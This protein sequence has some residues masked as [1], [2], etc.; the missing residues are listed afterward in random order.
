MAVNLST[1]STGVFARLGKLFGVLDRTI[2]FQD[3]IIDASTKSFQEAINEYI[4]VVG[5]AGGSTVNTDLRFV[6]NLTQGLDGFRNQVYALIFGKLHPVAQRTLVEMMCD[7]AKIANKSV[8]SALMELRDQM[9][10]SNDID[11]NAIGTT[12]QASITKSRANTGTVIIGLLPGQIY[13][14]NTEKIPT[15][16]AETITFKCTSDASARNV[17]KGGE[18]FMLEGETAYPA[19]DH[20]WPGGTGRMAGGVCTSDLGSDGRS[21]GRN[22]L[23]NSG[24]NNFASNVPASWEIVTGSAG[25]TIYEE[26]S[27]VARGSSC[28]KMASD[29]STTI[30]IKQKMDGR[31]A[32]DSN[33][34]KIEAD[35][36]CA[37][38]FLARKSGS[39]SAGAL[40]VGLTNADGFSFSNH[41]E[42]AHGDISDSAWTQVTTSF[43]VSPSWDFSDFY[44][45]LQQ[46]TA[47][48][49]GVNLFIDGLVFT[50]M[51]QTAPGGFHYAVVPGSVDFQMG[52]T[53]TTA[54]T[55]DGASTVATM[56]D[57]FFDIYHLG[58]FLPDKSDGSETIANSIIA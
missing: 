26:T 41:V 25:G 22:R 55:N 28:L 18:H 54:N 17:Q 14:S 20:R 51:Y 11:A 53:I 23:R 19:N 4:P 30:H 35:N 8:A 33:S 12:A 15:I 1:A 13:H 57:R 29:G 43:R 40:K 36:Y 7:D 44:F 16:R 45:S 24:F 2:T 6:S 39:T 34:G 48:T 38:S 58:V 9:G 21:K 56:M 5:T 37:I 27:T 3:D 46:T 42:V 47:F 52:D 32:G 49:N 50:T 10:S 31:G